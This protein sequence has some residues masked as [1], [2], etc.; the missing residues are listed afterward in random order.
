MEKH[1]QEHED[2][3]KYNRQND[4]QSLFGPNLEL[5][6]SRPRVRITCGQAEFLAQEVGGLIHEPTVVFA[7]QVDVDVAGE[8]AIF[9]ADHL[10]AARK[11]N[12]PNLLKRDLRA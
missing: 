9:V 11:G 1:V 12:L 2:H 5:I 4:L 10:R 8:L 3:K 7:V 6:L